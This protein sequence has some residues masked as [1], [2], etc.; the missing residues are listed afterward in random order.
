MRALRLAREDRY[1]TAAALAEAVEKAAA[2]GGIA[3]ATSRAVGAFIAALNVHARPVDLP[4]LPAPSS[5][6][7]PP[8]SARTPPPAP[9]VPAGD[10]SFT[11]ASRAR[12]RDAVPPPTSDPLPF[13]TTGARPNDT[14][15]RPGARRSSARLLVGAGA[16]TAVAATI[17]AVLVATSEDRQGRAGTSPA[18]SEEA[19]SVAAPSVAAPS[20]TPSPQ[21]PPVIE[22]AAQAAAVSDAGLEDAA[23]APAKS[24]ADRVEGA[25]RREPGRPAQGA[26]GEKPAEKG[27]VYRP[28]E[29]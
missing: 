11:P 9:V 25:P 13:S 7:P 24:A 27:P 17:V 14:G 15:S 1:A 18:V 8:V 28:P 5:S 4:G 23:A 19:P 29:L 10:A 26:S 16:I 22:P 6:F 12:A 2:V 20:A 21:P 3:I